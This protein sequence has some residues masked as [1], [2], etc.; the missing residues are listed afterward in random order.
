MLA[1]KCLLGED[2]AER[3][4]GKC[5]DKKKERMEAME[6]KE[7]IQR[8][9]RLTGITEDLAADEELMATVKDTFLLAWVKYEMNLEEFGMLMNKR[10]TVRFRDNFSTRENHCTTCRSGAEAKL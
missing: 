9:R 1:L 5:Q 10:R 8:L 3:N 4:L 6:K 2:L 7:L